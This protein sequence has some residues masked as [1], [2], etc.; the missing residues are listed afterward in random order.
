MAINIRSGLHTFPGYLYAGSIAI[1]FD[2][3]VFADILSLYNPVGSGKV[4]HIIS[5][6]LS[7]RSDGQARVI[8]AN[9][10]RGTKTLSGT[11]VT[12]SKLDSTS[13]ANVLQLNFGGTW[14]IGTRIESRALT[15]SPADNYDLTI[16]S[17]ILLREGEG[18]LFYIE[19]ESGAQVFLPSASLTW[20]EV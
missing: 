18:A 16:L 19:S 20:Y 8:T 3:P 15:C 9:F 17:P 2:L 5:G 6:S 10:N 1:N 11:V 7:A 4:G 14:S 12:P 13:P